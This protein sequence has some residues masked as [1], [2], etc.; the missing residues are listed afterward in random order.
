MDPKLLLVKM[1]TL[2]FKEGQLKD[3]TVH[4]ANLVKELI[5]TIK[6]PESSGGF[7]NTREVL[8]TLRTTVLWMSDTPPGEEIDRSSILQ[9]VR[10]NT[11]DEEGLY[12]AFEQAVDENVE[13]PVLKR[14]CI[15]LR[16]ELRDHINQTQIK[17]IL[18]QYSSQVNFRPEQ[19]D[20]RNIINEMNNKLEPYRNSASEEF[21]V[22]GMLNMVSLSDVEGVQ[23]MFQRAAEETSLDGILKTG[24]QAINRMLGDHGGFRRG[25]FVLIGALQH[26]WKTGFTLNIFKHLALYNKPHMR[27]PTK[28]PLLLH[29]SAENELHMNIV[30][31]YISLKENETLQEVDDSQFKD[32]NIPEDVRKANIARAQ[33]YIATRMSVNGYH[34]EMGR[35]DPSNTTYQSICDMVT[36]YEAQGYEIHAIV[37][38]YLNMI[39]KVGCLQGGPTGSEVRDL[40]RRVRNFMAPRGVT[41]ITPAQ[42]STDA[43]KMTRAGVNEFVKHLEGKGYYDSC[44]TIDQE[45]DLEI[46]IHKEVVNGDSF[47]TIQR[48]KHRKPKDTPIK[49]RYTVLP[50]YPAGAVRDDLGKADSSRK[51]P[52]GGPVGSE[53][54]NPWFAPSGSELGLPS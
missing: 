9:R 20:W 48:G 12:Y 25:E 41:F 40:F 39:S 22:A 24:Y 50:F 45:V 33:E 5:E 30:Q 36:Q 42:L 8:Q 15:Q 14:Q 51:T 3:P 1:A 19:V 27:D 23:Y 34:V 52:G 46:F 44:G 18:K 38:D 37:F 53:D 13:L 2:L 29:I 32:P 54:E 49:Y 28:K 21:K 11:A 43:K 31:L 10:I 47:L 26:Q 7:D 35:C 6:V 4:S 17:E 16:C